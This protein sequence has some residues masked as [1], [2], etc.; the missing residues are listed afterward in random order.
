MI[1]HI[2]H[3]ATHRRTIKNPKQPK[4]PAE[5]SHQ[6]LSILAASPQTP[7]SGHKNRKAPPRTARASRLSMTIVI[8]E[9]YHDSPATSSSF[10]HA[11]HASPAGAQRNENAGVHAQHLE[12][13]VACLVADLHQIDAAL[14]RSRDQ[15]LPATSPVW[16]RLPPPSLA[17]TLRPSAATVCALRSGSGQSIG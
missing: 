10:A 8:P 4:S 16:S 2:I 5:L 13:F 1:C 12:R 3:I 11:F 7:L 9:I 15:A 14:Y 17:S 6:S